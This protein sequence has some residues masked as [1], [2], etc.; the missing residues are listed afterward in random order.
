MKSPPPIV[1]AGHPALRAYAAPVPADLLGTRELDRLVDA[2]IAAMR[3]A[4]G[5][6]L[7]APQLGVGLR[8]IVLED[9]EELMARLSP[10]DRAARDRTPFPLTAIVNPTLTAVGDEAATFFEGCLSVPGYMALVARAREVAVTGLD[11]R[12]KAISIRVSG[13]PARSLQHEVDHLDGT[14]YVDRM[15]PRTL[16]VNA[17][18]QARW[19]LRPADEVIAA[20]D[21]TRA[22]PSRDR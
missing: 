4:P 20:L 7:A 6:G 2:M 15:M 5:V 22:P 13:W 3:A 9:R 8:L 1:S 12:G 11:P 16:S 18:C 14:L 19:L 17:E 10:A 21:A